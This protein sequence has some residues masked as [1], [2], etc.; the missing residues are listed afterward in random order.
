MT[1]SRHTLKCHNCT[2]EKVQKSTDS[3]STQH[4]LKQ[5]IKPQQVSRYSIAETADLCNRKRREHVYIVLINDIGRHGKSERVRL[6]I[7]WSRETWFYSQSQKS[8]FGFSPYV[9]MY[10]RWTKYKLLIRRHSK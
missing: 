1:L 4:V 8:Q 3:D 7:K 2:L 5:V 6:F 9:K 10:S